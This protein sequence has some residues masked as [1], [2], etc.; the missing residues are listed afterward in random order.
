MTKDSTQSGYLTK[1]EV[2]EWL[3]AKVE[4]LEIE[5]KALK[6]ILALLDSSS[7]TLAGEKVEEVKIGRRRVAKIYV[8]DTYVRASFENPVVLPVEVKEYLRSVE[9]DIRMLQVRSGV[10]GELAKLVV[11]EKPDGSVA[12]VRIENIQSTVEAIKAKAA[13]K[14]AIEITYQ[15]IKAKARELGDVELS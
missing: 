2:L 3:K 7:Q 13:L 8:G 5:L 4:E 10:E 12:E 1:E 6:T 14:Y 15:L 11:K 9:D